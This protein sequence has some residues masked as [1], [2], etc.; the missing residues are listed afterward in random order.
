MG[1]SVSDVETFLFVL[2]QEIQTKS[3]IAL[4]LIS[5]EGLTFKS[6]LDPKCFLSLFLFCRLERVPAVGVRQSFRRG[7]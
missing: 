1:V 4:P 7:K 2:K 5:F 3:Q 6:E